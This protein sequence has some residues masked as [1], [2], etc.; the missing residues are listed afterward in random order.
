[1][2][3]ASSPILLLILSAYFMGADTYLEL[4]LDPPPPPPV[5]ERVEEAVP[6]WHTPEL[7]PTHE[8]RRITSGFGMR[9]HPILR[10]RRMHH[11]IDFPIPEGTP[12]IATAD[13]TVS[14]I[15]KG[16]KGYGNYVL[17]DH[18]AVH[19][20]LYGHLSKIL[21]KECQNVTKGDTIAL[22]GNT[23][24]STRP[25]LHFEVWKYGR[26]VDPISYLPQ[27]TLKVLNR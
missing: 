12:V 3:L 21:V 17:L 2:K 20:S 9:M 4:P 23:G 8:L 14:R 19:H 7:A 27:Q 18:D 6:V 25:H 13:A 26:R 10:R 24:L 15:K 22:S 5:L 16:N 1:M 11:G